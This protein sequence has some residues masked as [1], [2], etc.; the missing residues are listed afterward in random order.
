MG[1]RVNDTPPGLLFERIVERSGLSRIFARGVVERACT[2]AKLEPTRLRPQDIA[3]LLPH[4]RVVIGVY[5]P[6]NE[7]QQRLVQIGALGAAARGGGDGDS[8]S[9][10]PRGGPEGRGG[11]P[12]GRL[13][14]EFAPG[15]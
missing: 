8:G 11:A 5:M 7:V 14:G 13:P 12:S 9:N 10:S 3:K 4:L 1:A 2:Q 15:P 6:P